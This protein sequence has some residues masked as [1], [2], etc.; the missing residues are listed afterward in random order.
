LPSSAPRFTIEGVFWARITKVYDGDTWH[1]ILRVNGRT[2]T[3]V[4]RLA[5]LDA[6]ELKGSSS[7]EKEAAA[8]VRDYCRARWLNK[9]VRVVSKGMEK[10]GRLLVTVYPLTCK[11]FAFGNSVNHH[12]I[13]K[14]YALAYDG[15]TKNQWTD[16]ALNKILKR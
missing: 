11:C 3:F 4:L 8:R 16:K 1:A 6:P 7:K 5:D 15:R 2:S 13:V 9:T 12:L 10:Y 14:G